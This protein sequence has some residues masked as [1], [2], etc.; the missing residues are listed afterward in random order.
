MLTVIDRPFTSIVPQE[1]ILSMGKFRRQ[2][3]ER[4]AGYPFI[5]G[6]LA[7]AGL[8]EMILK[9]L[10]RHLLTAVIVHRLVDLDRFGIGI[11]RVA[12]TFA[13]ELHDN[14]PLYPYLC[15]LHGYS[16]R[17]S[18][19]TVSPVKDA[20]YSR[21]MPPY[22]PVARAGF[23]QGGRRPLNRSHPDRAGVAKGI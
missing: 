18:K 14:R 5:A 6:N 9:R 13:N 19:K 7:E 12:W 11:V 20:R 17:S 23:R 16:G 4:G 21:Q 22:A 8:A 15:S 1:F 3:A 2:I 10:G